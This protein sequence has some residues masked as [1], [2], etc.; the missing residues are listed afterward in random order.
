MIN[1]TRILNTLL[2]TVRKVSDVYFLMF[3]STS[4]IQVHDLR[5]E[6]QG[7]FLPH[8][9][10]SFAISKVSVLVAQNGSPLTRYD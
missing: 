9:T 3:L 1:F 2:A 7:F 5:V 6:V 4:G 10:N 8:L